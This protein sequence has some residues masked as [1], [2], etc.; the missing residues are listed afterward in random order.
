M[1]IM[2]MTM[3]SYIYFYSWQM[4]DSNDFVHYLSPLYVILFSW[5][6][7]N[8]W[9]AFFKQYLNFPL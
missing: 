2:N 1:L 7:K 3:I 9:K 8:E 6:W 5:E 4:H